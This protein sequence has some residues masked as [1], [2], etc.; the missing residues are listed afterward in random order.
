M[1]SGKDP[2]TVSNGEEETWP[3]EQISIT[4]SSQVKVYPLGAGSWIWEEA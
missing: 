4:D 1:L 2:F 3:G